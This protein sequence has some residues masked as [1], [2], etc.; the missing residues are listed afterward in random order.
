NGQLARIFRRAAGAP[1][2]VS[3]PPAAPFPF[4]TDL[5][6]SWTGTTPVRETF[7][8]FGSWHPGVCQFVFCDG[9]VRAVKA[10]VDDTTRGRLAGRAEGQVL[11]GD[12]YPPR[13]GHGEG[14]TR[15][16]PAAAFPGPP[17]GNPSG[18]GQRVSLS[19][20]IVMS[21]GPRV[22]VYCKS[23]VSSFVYRRGMTNGGGAPPSTAGGRRHAR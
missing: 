20:L 14:G 16:R 12:Y 4:V 17:R 19:T 2:V 3:N 23:D 5:T 11:G 8:R 21:F 7:Q 15:A 10:G 9:S 13:A 18:A 6:D 22:M 1:T